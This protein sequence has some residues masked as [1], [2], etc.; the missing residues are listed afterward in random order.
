MG[1][2]KD[3]ISLAV[4]IDLGI[5]AAALTLL[6]LYPAISGFA[7]EAGIKLLL[8]N[9]NR[10]RR[11]FFWLVSAALTAW[12]GL[13]ILLALAVIGVLVVPRPSQPGPYG[14]E[15]WMMALAIVATVL[16]LVSVARS[17]WLIVKMT[18]DKV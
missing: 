10:R 17:G 15:H 13:L 14:H 11:L 5:L 9:E 12:L 7:R 18:L 16:S 1:E 8:H 3:L 4:T 6:A 2:L